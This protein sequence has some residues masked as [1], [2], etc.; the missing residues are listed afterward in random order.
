MRRHFHF[1]VF[2]P[3]GSG[4]PS[5]GIA[6]RVIPLAVLKRFDA[7]VK[8]RRFD[9]AFSGPVSAEVL[10]ALRLALFPAET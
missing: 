5:H 9:K 1:P 3:R 6:I 8:R 4:L 2:R 7:A 10:E